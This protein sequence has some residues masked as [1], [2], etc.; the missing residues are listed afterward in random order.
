MEYLSLQNR[1]N[2]GDPVPDEG[3]IKSTCNASVSAAASVAESVFSAYSIL[4]GQ[5]ARFYLWAMGY[6]QYV[7]SA[8][9]YVK[10]AYDATI[11]RI[12]SAVLWTL[13]ALLAIGFLLSVYESLWEYIKAVWSGDK[14]RMRFNTG[15]KLVDTA[16][17]WGAWIAQL[18]V[19]PLFLAS[20]IFFVFVGIKG[21]IGRLLFGP[22]QVDAMIEQFK[23]NAEL[24]NFRTEEERV[25]DTALATT[26]GYMQTGV[27]HAAAAHSMASL[28]AYGKRT[29][30]LLATHGPRV[31]SGGVIKT[32]FTFDRKSAA[33]ATWLPDGDSLLVFDSPA[34]LYKPRPRVR[35]ES[36]GDYSLYGTMT[37]AMF[38]VMRFDA[39][40]T[41]KQRDVFLGA[42]PATAAAPTAQVYRPSFEH[43]SAS[44]ASETTAAA[45]AEAPTLS[46]VARNASASGKTAAVEGADKGNNG[47]IVCFGKM[48]QAEEY[49]C[50]LA[51]CAPLVALIARQFGP[52]TVRFMPNSV[53]REFY[54]ETSDMLSDVDYLVSDRALRAF[55]DI[56]GP[57]PELFETREPGDPVAIFTA[58]ASR[59][60]IGGRPLSDVYE[61]VRGRDAVFQA[62]QHAAAG[63]F[64]YQKDGAPHCTA[65]YSNGFGAW[66]S[67]DERPRPLA[68]CE[69]LL[70]VRLRAASLP[71]PAVKQ[72][73]AIV[74][75]FTPPPT[76]PQP[77]MCECAVQT[78]DDEPP[79]PAASAPAL[80]APA[81]ASAPASAPAA[82]A[83]A[84]TASA[85]ALPAPAP[86]SSPASL[87]A[88]TSEQNQL[89]AAPAAQ[90]D[91]ALAEFPARWEQVAE[92][93]I[94]T[95]A[96]FTIVI[97][98]LFAARSSIAHC[99]SM[100]LAMSA[101]IAAEF[102]AR[103]GRVDELA[104]QQVKVGDVGSLL[105]KQNPKEYGYYLI[106]KENHAGKPALEDF[107]NAVESFVP[108]LVE[109]H[110]RVV[111]MPKLG[112]GLDG[113]SIGKTLPI[114]VEVFG[115][116]DKS[117]VMCVGRS[118]RDTLLAFK[119]IAQGKDLSQVKYFG[120]KNSA[121][122]ASSSRP[123]AASSS[124]SSAAPAAA[125][126]SASP[127]RS[128]A[129]P[130]STGATASASAS[131]ALVRHTPTCAE[132]AQLALMHSVALNLAFAL[133]AD[134]PLA[135]FRNFNHMTSA[136]GFDT[137]SGFGLDKE[138]AAKG[139]GS[140]FSRMPPVDGKPLGVYIGWGQHKPAGTNG[141]VFAAALW[142]DGSK[143]VGQQIPHWWAAHSIK[144]KSTGQWGV[145]WRQTDVGGEHDKKLTNGCPDG[146]RLRIWRK[147]D[148]PLK[149]YAPPTAAAASNCAG[150]DKPASEH[151]APRS[152]IQ[153][154]GCN[155][156]FVGKCGAGSGAALYTASN[157]W[158]CRDCT[159]AGKDKALPK[160]EVKP[161]V[162]VVQQPP[163]AAPRVPV[164]GHPATR[165]PA[166]TPAKKA[167]VVVP[168]PPVPP[169]KKLLAKK[170]PVVAAPQPGLAAAA[171]PT[172]AAVI[173][174]GHGNV[175]F[176]AERP[177]QGLALSPE[178]QQRAVPPRRH[179]TVPAVSAL[180][181]TYIDRL[182]LISEEDLHQVMAREPQQQPAGAPSHPL[183]Y[184]SK[185]L[186]TRIF[187]L[188]GVTSF[189]CYVRSNMER[190]K[191]VP[192]HQAA[193]EFLQFQRRRAVRPWLPQTFLRRLTN[194]H[195]ALADLELYA[196]N[197][198][199]VHLSQVAEWRNAL[200]AVTALVNET[201]LPTFESCTAEEVKQAVLGTKTTAP[202][203]AAAILLQWLV[204]AR[205]GDIQS[206]RRRYVSISMT[207]GD[208]TVQIREGKTTKR[209]GPYTIASNLQD[210]ELRQ[211]LNQYLS[212]LSQ[213]SLVVPPSEDTD[214]ARRRRTT[215]INS[216][217]KKVRK[218][219]ATRA[220][221]RGA[222]QAMATGAM[223][224]RPVDVTTLMSYSGHTNEK[225]LK[226]YLDWGRL[227][228][229]QTVAQ[230][231][232]AA[233]LQC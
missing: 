133:P 28:T 78:V 96:T 88:A 152:S 142:E 163:P 53:K 15:I 123:T 176:D 127:V 97:G 218:G 49:L 10:P 114:L 233:N 120:P 173:D 81:P 103:F 14:R 210:Q 171:P 41:L 151:A 3:F 232:A 111:A 108:M 83:P 100:D 20:P 5:A 141:Y 175:P 93:R 128:A 17:T 118:D 21:V 33:Q 184:W 162:V 196:K 207:T 186:S 36:A 217:L 80:V 167:P 13:L 197:G 74:E 131:S 185:A 22:S 149:G 45:A 201:S 144:D 91:A 92:M 148:E 165:A 211:F 29:A 73:P 174:R 6:R 130:S 122:A 147:R 216:E 110:Q 156:R 61:F 77:M 199:A 9:S 192:L 182:V 229:Q 164:G 1:R 231:G 116:H 191:S 129:A 26:V 27:T 212:T 55:I 220:V 187:H 209:R 2:E 66:L 157:R 30:E 221:R 172:T 119:R 84:P 195:G 107:R 121:S 46:S 154:G 54:D 160:R 72:R 90:R 188:R 43:Y 205:T 125:S 35:I 70:L 99:V 109:H 190:M 181:G 87:P 170:A 104:A 24:R 42:P 177:A 59:I 86:A 75:A 34:E 19:Q 150:C 69:A 50:Y 16:L 44:A 224:G 202:H 102:R 126:T 8:V 145:Q 153:C 39:H 89:A 215:L 85:P 214:K 76:S 200:T 113:L 67:F 98:D 64:H 37:H 51:L 68:P 146:V 31:G 194:L 143:R 168:P 57:P 135:P 223:N 183:A 222:L 105:I 38:A 132:S 155:K 204:A 25:L 208:V 11:G 180:P 48:V 115:Q 169:A 63:I 158:F 4:A 95:S 213:D 82:S 47:H 124:P 166:K 137:A 117:F 7:D 12:P 193:M 18:V 101:G 226:R 161:P 52:G 230:R 138:D 179:E 106:S 60:E 159:K 62:F 228:G 219:L 71:A 65:G 40:S 23:A 32:R 58:V 134:H 225:M 140:I 94:G 56:A 198:Q 139:I 178:Q 206:L 136:K 227:F 203:L 189:Q 79:A 112:C